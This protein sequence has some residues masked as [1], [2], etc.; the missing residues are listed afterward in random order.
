MA[1][2]WKADEY[3]CMSHETLLSISPWKGS[4]KGVHFTTH[5][6]HLVHCAYYW[7]KM[8][9]AAGKGTIIEHRYNNMAHLDHCEMMFLKRDPLGTIVTTAGVSLHLDVV[10]IAKKHGHG[11]KH[12]EDP[13]MKSM[14]SY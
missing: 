12:D 5:Q 11:H 14:D 3:Q 6:W 9:L 10:V 2:L 8:F 4:T 1:K 13:G 7:K